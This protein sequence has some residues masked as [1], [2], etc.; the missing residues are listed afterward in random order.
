MSFP[1]T[2]PN[3]PI[4]RSYFNI[5]VNQQIFGSEISGMP[6]IAA[7]DGKTDRWVGAYITPLLSQTQH[8]LFH[9]WVLSLQGRTGTFQ[10]FDPDRKQPSTLSGGFPGNGQVNG[11]GQTGTS[12]ATSSWPASSL[13]LRAGDLVQ[14]ES[15]LYEMTADVNS[16]GLGE[17]T[18]SFEPEIRTSPADLA[19]V[20]TS[21]PVMIARLSSPDFSWDTDIMKTGPVTI[22]FEEAL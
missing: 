6:T 1:L 13:I 18:L 3:I 9:A 5:V 8:D 4:A 11:A 12:L 19:S 7:L 2:F 22:A 10:A 17:A 21:S 15:Q 20:I 16:D 14:I